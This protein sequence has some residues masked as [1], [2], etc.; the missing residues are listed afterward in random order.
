MVLS[1]AHYVVVP[2]TMEWAHETTNYTSIPLNSETIDGRTVLNVSKSSLHRYIK[3]QAAFYFPSLPEDLVM[4]A[5]TNSY[6]PE[7][8]D[9]VW[10]AGPHAGTSAYFFPDGGTLWQGLCILHPTS[11][12]TCT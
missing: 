3:S 12:P 9:V 7:P 5:Y 4:E 10:D 11:T 2:M 6:E 1:K 8:G